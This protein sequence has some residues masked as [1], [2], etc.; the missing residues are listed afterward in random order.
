MV[1]PFCKVGAQ[2]AVDIQSRARQEAPDTRLR[3]LGAVVVSYW[4]P[5][6]DLRFAKPL[7]A[8]SVHQYERRSSCH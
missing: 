1:D 5:P 8:A 7:A 3:L 4:P 6:P 2:A